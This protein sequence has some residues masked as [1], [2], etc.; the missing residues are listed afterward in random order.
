[1]ILLGVNGLE[2]SF[3]AEELFSQVNFSVESGEKIGL[4]GANGCGKTTLFKMITGEETTDGGQITLAKGMKLSYMEQ[5]MQ[6]SGSVYEECLSCFSDLLELEQRIDEINHVL[7]QEPTPELI[8]RQ[9][10]LQEQFFRDGGA[11]FRSR[12]KGVLTG[13]GFSEQEFSA[14]QLSGGQKTR[15]MLAKILLSRADLLLLDEPT[16]HL[17]IASVEWLERYLKEYHG[18]F[19]VISHDRYFLDKVTDKTFA[20]ANES[21]KSYPGN[22]TRYL[23]LKEEEQKTIT[24]NYENTQRE[25]KR[26]EGIIAQQKQWNR[27]RNIRTAEHKQK[28]I[29]RLQ[30]NLVVPEEKQKSIRLSFGVDAQGPQEFLTVSGAGKAF[31]EKRIFQNVSMQ[32]RQKNRVFL[33]GKNGCGKTTLLKMILG[34]CSGEGDF[35]FGSNVSVGYYDQMQSDLPPGK[36]VLDTLWDAYPT[37]TKTELCNALAAFLFFGD[38]V[39]KSVDVLSGGEKARVLLCRLM[40]SGANFL[41]LDEPT[42]HLDISSRE[43]LEEALCC[44]EGTLFMISHDRYFIN[45][46]ATKIYELTPDGAMCYDGDY[47]YY[48]EKRVQRT[49]SDEKTEKKNLDYKEAKEKRSA[50]NRAAGKLNRCEEEIALLEQ[51]IETLQQQMEENASD[52]NKSMELFSECEEKKVQLESLMEEWEQLSQELEMI[53]S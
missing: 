19:I 4:V 39:E 12:I 22:Y 37:K 44:Y 25:I 17:D 7:E 40:L 6:F 21:L 11:E 32:V 31:G 47:D 42:N 33:L 10:Q 34:Q 51:E 15:L 23:H 28:S 8:E 52:Y 43:A 26:I 50:I 49:P 20:M 14:Q 36:T 48:L 3:G 18:A 24:R 53:K 35:V 38:D 30:E 5:L 27:E 16:N 9:H 2:K 13:L 1:M 45:R 46:L 41:L 29:D